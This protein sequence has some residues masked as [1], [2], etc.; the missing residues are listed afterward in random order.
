MKHID[1]HAFLQI[2]GGMFSKFTS[3]H[4]VAAKNDVSLKTVLQVRGSRNFKEYTQQNKAQHPPVEYSLGENVINLHDI[5]FNKHDSK[6]IAPKVARKALEE[7]KLH[8]I[9]E[10]RNNDKKLH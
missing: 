6:Y 8:F 7:L 3:V 9:Q 10:N 2:K 4:R 1:E 5:V